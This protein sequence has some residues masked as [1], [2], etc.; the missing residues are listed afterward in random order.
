MTEA[1]AAAEPVAG[2]P[3]LAALLA[4]IHAQPEESAPADPEPEPEDTPDPA[5]ESDQE[6]EPDFPEEPEPEAPKKRRT[7]LIAAILIL[8]AV[9]VAVAVGIFILRPDADPAQ[10][11]ASVPASASTSAEPSASASAP[12][13]P[14]APA[15]PEPDP[16][17]IPEQVEDPDNAQPAESGQ[18]TAPGGEGEDT[19]GY[20][21]PTSGSAYLTQE[22]LAGLTKEELR[23]ARNE[24]YAR[25]GYDFTGTDLA[26]YFAAQPWYTPLYSAEEFGARDTELLNEYELANLDLIRAAENS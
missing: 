9:A 19:S 21:L 8:A 12:E 11:D 10:P 1:P 5:A 26:G 20:I 23:L 6:P 25:K 2:D 13:E 22:D 17:P 3:E 4:E 16:T 7:G 24:I 15:E 14:D 18:E